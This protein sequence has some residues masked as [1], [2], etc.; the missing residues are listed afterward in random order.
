MPRLED[1]ILRTISEARVPSVF[2]FEVCAATLHKQA[3]EVI[4]HARMRLALLVPLAAMSFACT[5][6]SAAGPRRVA[7]R[8][9]L[10]T[11]AAPSAPTASNQP[12]GLAAPGNDAQLVELAK[13]AKV[14]PWSGQALSEECAAG[15]A[16]TNANE[17]FTAGRADPTL[18]SLLED[19]DERVRWL[20]ATK[21]H[22]IGAKFATE[23]PLAER[24]VA[25][26]EH[27]TSGRV[28]APLGV[29]LADLQV[30]KTGTFDRVRA[31]AVKHALPQ[32]RASL[33]ANLSR[34]N[35][36]VSAAFE[37]TR[38]LVRDPEKDV[39]LAAIGAFYMRGGGKRPEDTCQ[40]WVQNLDNEMDS[41]VASIANELLSRWGR[42]QAFYGAL[43]ESQAKRLEVGRTDSARYPASLA[44]ICEDKRAQPREKERATELV[45]K[46]AENKT[47]DA[48]VRA[49]ALDGALVCDPA[50]GRD[51]VKKFAN[52]PPALLKT[53]AIDLLRPKPR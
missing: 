15:I 30:E 53:R 10:P 45:H 21:L 33:V 13:K 27:E 9:A 3:G 44:Q 35:P 50:G 36:G 20:A 24:V 12:R 51:F 1:E 43:L 39:R 48:E 46:I 5:D 18:V 4:S 19:T 14:C 28:G 11:L 6:D 26:G 17:G 38:E 34:K 47:L 37:L 49:A 31:I 2:T 29:L 22:A 8:S 42:C 7:S 40:I 52:D 32:L 16:W 23:R 41:D 25:A